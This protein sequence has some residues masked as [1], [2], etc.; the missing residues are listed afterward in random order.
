MTRGSPVVVSLAEK[1]A[2]FDERWSPKIIGELNGQY[3]K[4]AKLEGEL[5]WHAHEHED[6]LFLVLSGTLILRL[7]DRDLEL[8][9][10]EMTIIPRGVQHLPIARGEVH[11]LLFEPTSTTSTGDTD[12]PR[13]TRGAW[14]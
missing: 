4:L 13:N 3:V 8:R 14:L 7:A 10:G 1:L 6:E 5:A 9:P 12:D 2:T 11:V